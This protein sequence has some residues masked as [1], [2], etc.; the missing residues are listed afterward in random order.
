MK[1]LISSDKIQEQLDITAQTLNNVFEGRND[2]VCMPILQGGVKFFVDL[3]SRFTF[4]PIVKYAGMSSYEGVFS[5]EIDAYKLPK[6]E[7]VNGKTVLVFDDILDTGNTMDFII[8]FLFSIGAKEVIPVFLLG[9]K[10]KTYQF[11]PRIQN[12]F[13]LFTIGEEWVFGYG[14][15]NLTGH[16]RTLNYIAYES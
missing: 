12:T 4:N 7:D 11:D 10:T 6:S 5:Q 2:V 3:S 9:R 16:Y 15:D 8:R 13:E 1:E 14:M